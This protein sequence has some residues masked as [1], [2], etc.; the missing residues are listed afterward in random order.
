ML[1]VALEDAVAQESDKYVETRIDSLIQSYMNLYRIPGLSIGIVKSGNIYLT[2]GY[3]VTSVDQGYNVTDSTFF[4]VC[5]ITKLF[6]ATAIMQLSEQ[7]KIDIHKRLIDYI[8]G[9]EMKDK[10]YKEITVY[11]L[12]THTS[13]ISWDNYLK[14]SPDDSSALKL[15]IY[16]LNKTKLNFSPGENFGGETYSN[17]GYDILGYLVEDISGMSYDQY[18]IQHILTPVQISSTYIHEEIPLE[19]KAMPHILYGSTREIKKF[20]LYGV[21]KDE[22]P[23]IKYSDNPIVQYDVYSG[24]REHDPSAN[25]NTSVFGLSSWMS[26]LLHV[27][28]DSIQDGSTVISYKSL[29]D[30]WSLKQSIRNKK[31]SIGLGWW[32][33]EDDKFGDYVFHVGRDPGFCSTLMIF[34]EQNFGITILCNGMYA[35]QLVWNTLPFEIMEILK[36]KKR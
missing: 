22:N 35:D 12:L 8:P 10:R 33:Y 28:M 36:M 4:K 5:S 9:F 32:R 14:D 24:T 29:T 1:F 27:Y 25:L 23:V 15:F 6:T 34:P 13:G 2:K 17:T 31:T 7:G 3:G 18:V 19:Q 21:V 11:H 20:N 16:S 26:H 30:M